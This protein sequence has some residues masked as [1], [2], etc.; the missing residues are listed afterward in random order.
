MAL[1]WL[2]ALVL[3]TALGSAPELRLGVLLPGGD[4][5]LPIRDAIA[6]SILLALDAVNGNG[7]G[8]GNGSANGPEIQWVWQDSRCDGASAAAALLQLRDEFEVDAVVGPACSGALLQVAPIAE[9]FQL[10]VLSFGASVP[11]VDSPS[12]ARVNGDHRVLRHALPS[13]STFYG[14]SRV[15]LLVS[16]DAASSA[17]AAWLR[18]QQLPGVTFGYVEIFAEGSPSSVASA[19]EMLRAGADRIVLVLAACSDLREVLLY[20]K[21]NGMLDGFAYLATEVHPRCHEGPG[22]AAAGDAEA[23]EAFEGLLS[24]TWRIP[25]S[26][27]FQRFNAS[28]RAAHAAN[29]FGS[30]ASPPGGSLLPLLPPASSSHAAPEVSPF[31]VRYAAL[32]HD[33]IGLYASAAQLTAR[34]GRDARRG[35]DVLERL[36]RAA[37]AGATGEVRVGEDLDRAGLRDATVYCVVNGGGNG[38]A[39]RLEEVG[40]SFAS[41]APYEEV[42]VPQWPGNAS[43]APAPVL[44]PAGEFLPEGESVCAACEAGRFKPSEGNDVEL[45]ADCESGRFGV[46]GICLALPPE[47]KNEIPDTFRAIVIALNMGAICVSALL[48]AMVCAYQRLVVI[49]MAQPFFL[50]ITCVGTILGSAASFLVGPTDENGSAD[51]ATRQCKAFWFL[52]STAFVLGTAGLIAKTRRVRA[53][54]RAAEQL[55]HINV[56]ELDVLSTVVVIL[57]VD[58]CILVVW[59]IV[60]P[61]RYER[62]VTVRDQYGNAIESTGRCRSEYM[63]TFLGT[64]IGFHLLV[65]AYGNW[66]CYLTRKIDNVLN[67]SRDITVAFF[68]KFQLLA[69]ATVVLTLVSDETATAYLVWGVLISLD[70]FALLGALFAPKVWAVARGKDAD[71]A[72]VIRRSVTA[73]QGSNRRVRSSRVAARSGAQTPSSGK[74]FKLSRTVPVTTARGGSDE[75]KAS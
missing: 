21:R 22:G 60:A 72:G 31:D 23:R 48:V 12:V 66:L 71:L 56:R 59:E 9:Y 17:T 28:L 38:S 39:L 51:D 18:E 47:E 36:P 49:R 67:E 8:D 14:W 74:R 43:S 5:G 61:L 57:A 2:P 27:A 45:C 13:L 34:E 7:N 75:S 53:V 11:T 44:C 33:A 63:S 37:F 10:P 3:G 29:A 6:P 42:M 26:A 40:V 19:M 73:E 55:H 20:A 70:N 25:D 65:L 1:R 64:I 62:E 58:L 24:I 41:S 4:G 16:T 52:F 32:L 69:L 54:L 68:N 46:Q 35:A 50:Y 30:Y 15:A